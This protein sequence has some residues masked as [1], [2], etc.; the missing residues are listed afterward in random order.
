MRLKIVKS[1]LPEKKN[2]PFEKRLSQ[3]ILNIRQTPAFVSIVVTSLSR[4]QTK[5]WILVADW[6]R[7]QSLEPN[8]GDVTRKICPLYFTNEIKKSNFTFWFGD[9]INNIKPPQLFEAS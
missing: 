9:N 4:D 3:L 6:L 8:A 7:F 2:P 5:T 1:N